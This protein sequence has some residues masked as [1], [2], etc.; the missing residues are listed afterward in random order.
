M[1]TRRGD[2]ACVD[3]LSIP[4]GTCFWLRR[5]VVANVEPDLY[6]LLYG[7]RDSCIYP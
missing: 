2:H 3:D 4:L 1:M 7:G 6:G 5:L